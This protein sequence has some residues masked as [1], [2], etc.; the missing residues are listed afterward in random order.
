MSDP[1]EQAARILEKYAEYRRDYFH[2]PEPQSSN[3]IEQMRPTDLML[4]AEV[5]A[6][7]K[8]A[9]VLRNPREEY[10]SLALPSWHWDAWVVFVVRVGEETNH[11]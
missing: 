9:K 11:E 8:A 10:L 6:F 3:D 7:E 4:W 2:G 5:Q 1:V